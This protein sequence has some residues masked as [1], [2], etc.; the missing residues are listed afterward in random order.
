MSNKSI[1]K[2][3]VEFSQL[4]LSDGARAGE[5]HESW[6]ARELQSLLHI[7]RSVMSRAKHFFSAVAAAAA[8]THSAVE[9]REPFPMFVFWYFMEI[10]LMPVIDA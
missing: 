7:S 10:F 6:Q 5:Q 4:L 3:H 2:T 9:N 8:V 1:C